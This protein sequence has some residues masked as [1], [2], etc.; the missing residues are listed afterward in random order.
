MRCHAGAA[1]WDVVG[2]QFCMLGS[3][4]QS[5]HRLIADRDIPQDLLKLDSPAQKPCIIDNKCI[6]FPDDS[7]N[8]YHP[9]SKLLKKTLRSACIP[10]T[11]T[12][13]HQQLRVRCRLPRPVAGGQLCSELHIPHLVW[14][15]PHV[16]P[17][18]THFVRSVNLQHTLLCRVSCFSSIFF[19]NLVVC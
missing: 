3:V 1:Y 13:S 17:P 6:M 18:L 2:E 14:P 15:A 10:P 5:P 11:V 16:T 4:S 9:S 8:E 7:L 12:P 19:S